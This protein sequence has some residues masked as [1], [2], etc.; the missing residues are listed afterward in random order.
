M[1][2]T[3]ASLS[4]HAPFRRRAPRKLRLIAS[5][6]VGILVMAAAVSVMAASAGLSAPAQAAPGAQITV[7]GSGFAAGQAGN[8]TYNGAVVTTF[9]ASTSGAF[10]VTVTIPTSAALGSTARISAKTELPNFSHVY[11]IIFENKEYSSVVGSSAAPYI[12]SLIAK[13]GLST[14]FTPSAIRPSPTTSP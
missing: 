3:P 9:A 12:N 5:S 4:N 13:Y 8:L 10:S 2:P 11:V 14:N 1:V 7:S 6:A